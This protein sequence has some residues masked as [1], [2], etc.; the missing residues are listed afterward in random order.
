[1]T[2]AVIAAENAF[3]TLKSMAPALTWKPIADLSSIEEANALFC[4]DD[5]ADERD[6]RGIDIPVFIHSLVKPLQQIRQS[7]SVVRINAWTGF[8]NRALWEVAGPLSS[9]HVDVLVALSRTYKQV[10]DEPGFVAARVIAM[11]INE[12]YMA[13]EEG[14]SSKADI[15]IAMKLGTNYPMGP[16][17]WADSVGIASVYQLLYTLSLTDERYTPANALKAAAT[18]HD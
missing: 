17:E 12:A 1:M 18:A 9:G 14:V 13:L 15:D 8:L 4:L 16:F 10:P 3:D 11:I 5:G 2:I 7:G 6:Y